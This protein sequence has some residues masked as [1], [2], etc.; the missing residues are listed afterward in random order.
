MNNMKLSCA[1][2]PGL[3][4]V[5]HV[6]LAEQLGYDGAW[7][8]DSPALYE[9]VWMVLAL[10]ADRTR[11]IR[12]GPAVLVP[13]LRHVLVTASAIATL[14]ELAPSRVSVAIGTGFT[15]RMVLGQRPLPWSYVEHYVRTL[16]ALL[17]GEHVTVDGAAVAMLHPEGYAPARPINTPII[18]AAAGPKGTAIAREVGDGI[19]CV[20]MP[21]PGF[22][23]CALLTFG[24]V[25]DDGELPS[26]ER[27]LAAA[28][29]AAAVAFHGVYESDPAAVDALPGGAT[30]RAAIEALPERERHLA[31]HEGH[32]VALSERDRAALDPSTIPAFTFT[33][34]ASEVRDRVKAVVDAGATEILYAPIGPDI[35][36]EL[37]T[38]KNAV[39]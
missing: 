10:A 3:R 18:V 14:E 33:G 15:G 9:D 6:Q 35:E 13:D 37:T 25:L 36:R 2:P 23:S 22:D 21:Q 16:R 20:V 11:S 7:F 1:F 32:L 38:F 30:W 24:T 19:M 27:V 39:T 8:Y 29:P 4:H 17:H 34:P 31:I 28:G 5:E 12:L 26:D